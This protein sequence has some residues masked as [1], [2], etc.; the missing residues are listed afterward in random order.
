MSEAKTTL[1]LTTKRLF[2]L[3]AFANCDKLSTLDVAQK[4]IAAGINTTSI[5]FEWADAPMRELRNA[6]LLAYAEGRDSSGRRYHCLT[7][8]GK[9]SL[10]ATST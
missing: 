6:G 4:A 7:E 1:N 3:Q 2:C 8:M 10:S 9:A 5:R